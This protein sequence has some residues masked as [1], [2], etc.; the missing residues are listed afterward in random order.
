MKVFINILKSVIIFYWVLAAGLFTSMLFFPSAIDSLYSGYSDFVELV[1]EPTCLALIPE[2]GYYGEVETEE[3]IESSKPKTS[4]NGEAS[5]V[6]PSSDDEEPT[7][8]ETPVTDDEEPVTD[9]EESTEPTEDET[10]VTDDEE[11]TEPTED[12]TP[13]T[14]DEEL[15][16]DEEEST[17]PTEDE[18]VI[19]D[20][21]EYVFLPSITSREEF[22]DQLET[23]LVYSVIGMVPFTFLVFSF[24]KKYQEAVS[25]PKT[26]A[27]GK[28]KDK[29]VKQKAK[30]DKKLAKIQSIG[31]TGIQIKK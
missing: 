4:S 29:I 9:E 7:E 28:E 26:A 16:T 19:E 6:E 1:D 8:D 12:E 14:D 5:E 11:P 18:T 3:P 15:V 2:C 10:P 20:E 21:E 24:S 22:F 23:L 17:E 13:V 30:V 27:S 25:S 31:V